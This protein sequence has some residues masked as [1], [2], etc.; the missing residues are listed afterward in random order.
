MSGLDKA[1]IL[2]AGLGLR[3]RPLTEN[4]PKPLIKVMGKTLLDHAIDR[5][6]QGGVKMI[7]VNVH[8]RA[9]QIVTHLKSRN[10][11]EIRICDETGEIL[12]SG[13]GIAKALPHFNGEPFFVYNSDTLWVEGVS[14][15][16]AR[17]QA[18]WDAAAMDALMLLAPTVTAI[19]Y[20]GDG[21]FD[22]GLRPAPA[23]QPHAGPSGWP[24]GRQHI[25]RV[26]GNRRAAAR[27]RGDA[28]VRGRFRKAIRRSA[29]L[30]APRRS[31]PGR[32]RGQGPSSWVRECPS[33]CP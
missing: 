30:T 22:L 13:G 1:M 19:G 26:R 25:G 7:V 32:N 33:Q 6:V 27:G 16:V 3:M 11:V 29:S 18:R 12:D 20:D 2:A 17:M 31:P 14:R 5:L 21:D 9:D 23:R 10:D 15:A 4:T 28:R 8:Y 24:A